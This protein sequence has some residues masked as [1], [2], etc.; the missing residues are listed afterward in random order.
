VS[1]PLSQNKEKTAK[2]I[3]L[4]AELD[5]NISEFVSVANGIKDHDEKFY[6]KPETASYAMMAEIAS[7]AAA[8]ERETAAI[9][10]EFRYRP[11]DGANA[12]ANVLSQTFGYPGF[13]KGIEMPFG[14]K[15][16]PQRIN[17][18][19]GVDETIEVPWGQLEV[20]D[21]EAVFHLGANRDGE[22]G[23]LFMLTIELPK[24][25]EKA[26]RGL[27]NQIE[28]YLK[29]NS[30]YKGKAITG[31]ETPEFI[32]L[33]K[34]SRANF[35]YKREVDTALEAEIWNPLRYPALYEKDGQPLRWIS[36]L[37]GGYG[38]GKTSAAQL[39]AQVATENGWTF[40]QARPNKDN[41]QEVMSLAHIYAP[42]VVFYED[43]DVVAN[44]PDQGII[45]SLLEAFDG[46]RSKGHPVSVMMTTNHPEN[47]HPGLIRAGRLHTYLVFGDLDQEALTHLIQVKVG[48][49]QLKADLD[50]DAVY[51]SC[52]QYSPSFMALVIDLAKRYAFFDWTD[53]VRNEYLANNPNASAEQISA[54]VNAKIEKESEA[55]FS[56]QLSTENLVDAALRL[57]EQWQLTSDNAGNIPQALTL[58]NTFKKY[59]REEAVRVIEHSGWSD[60]SL[61]V[62]ND[63][64]EQDSTTA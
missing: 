34:V 32:D 58:D 51:D 20:P 30:I 29:T 64:L 14:G 50:Y 21:M 62:R 7:K 18:N 47:I 2:I 8:E 35:V 45:S 6:L 54:Y 41:L 15:I 17:V 38:T 25:F 61:W 40:I 9:T 4:L 11:W 57:R 12:V 53:V 63:D 3:S 19:V 10:R 13:G 23:L 37:A 43:V 33:S 5:E 24:K 59:I 1:T 55:D 27:M 16:P 60:E 28:A 22:L 39:T 36:L 26:A 44:T 31:G 48:K 49:A 46:M 56:Y 42:A 52:K